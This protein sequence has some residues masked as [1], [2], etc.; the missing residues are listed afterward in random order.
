MSLVDGSSIQDLDELFNQGYD[1]VG[2][3]LREEMGKFGAKKVQE[4]CSGK[5]QKHKVFVWDMISERG[6]LVNK[7]LLTG[8]VRQAP[9]DFCIV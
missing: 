2:L 1:G 4:K 7:S 6:Q 3:L 5:S 9:L 8:R